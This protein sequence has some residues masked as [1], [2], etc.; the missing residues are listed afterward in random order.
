MYGYLNNLLKYLFFVLL[1]MNAKKSL[2][3]F[4]TLV[5]YLNKI[6]KH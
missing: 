5:K 3:K 1:D 6:K 4:R 2:L